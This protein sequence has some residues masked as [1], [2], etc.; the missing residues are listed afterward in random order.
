MDHDFTEIII[1][2]SFPEYL[3]ELPGLGTTDIIHMFIVEPRFSH[4]LA[5]NNMC[6]FLELKKS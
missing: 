4:D 6:I 1:L 3:Y 5:P 2:T